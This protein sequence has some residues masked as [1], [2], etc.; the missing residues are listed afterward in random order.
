MTKENNTKKIIRFLMLCLLIVVFPFISWMYL[1]AGF[2]YQKEAWG[3]LQ[4]YGSLS[5]FTFQA[6]NGKEISKTQLTNKVVLAAF[7]SANETQNER[8]I[9]S[10]KRLHDQFDDREDVSFALLSTQAN[11]AASQSMLAKHEIDDPNQFY[12]LSGSDE[13]VLDLMRKNFK[14]PNMEKGRGDDKKYELSVANNLMPKDYPYFVL[15]DGKGLIRNYY[16]FRN[17]EH[18]K[19]VV[20]HLAILMPRVDG[21][22]EAA[23]TKVD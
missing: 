16:D 14:Q 8:Q 10:M 15:V 9:E 5:A 12:L 3:E 20:E 13:K 1:R 11:K 21:R 17:E 7:Y 6:Q 18:I 2:N 4:D 19:R 22:K 23:K